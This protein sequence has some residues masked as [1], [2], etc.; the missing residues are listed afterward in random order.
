MLMS[1]DLAICNGI[2]LSS[3]NCYTPFIGSLG[4]SNG[5]IEYVG[6]RKIFPGEVKEYVDAEN[7]IVMPGLVNGHCHADMAFARGLGDDLTLREQNQVFAKSN[8]FYD[9]TTEEERYYSRLLTYIE[10]ILSGT[11]F[12]LDNTFWDLG[13]R[14]F[15]A[16]HAVGIKGGLV[17][18]FCSSFS[19]PDD[20]K[21]VTQL[22]A[23]KENCTRQW[24][25]P[26]FGNILEEDLSDTRLQAISRLSRETDSLVTGYLTETQWR[27]EIVEERFQATA[28]E[29]LDRNAILNEKYIGS[30][31][32]YLS[33][34]DIDIL[35]TKGVKIVNTP[36][37]EMKIADGIAPIPKLLRKGIVVGLGTD[38]AMWNNTNDIFGEMKCMALLQTIAGGIRSITTNEILD[39]ATINGARVFGLEKEIGTIE[40]GKKADL[41]LVDID[42]PYF[43]PVRRKNKPNVGSSIVFGATGRDVTD[44]FIDGRHIVQNKKLT[45]ID[46]DDVMHRVNVISEKIGALL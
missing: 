30:H 34:E 35:S 25:A 44:V 26:V 32:V 13:S 37:C 28:V 4:I 19:K 15:D 40:V 5:V 17:N 27:K 31:G 20:F 29:I 7:K 45:T 9:I 46:V 3:H 18:D 14:A 11:T 39:M 6:Q 41:I 2:I 10:A 21:P 24:I 12:L 1:F 22:T 23:W 36:I 16:F 43:A 38:G 33:D 42:Q 8:W